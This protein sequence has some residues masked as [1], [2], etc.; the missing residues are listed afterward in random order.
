[1]QIPFFQFIVETEGKKEK[2]GKN[3]ETIWRSCFR[4]NLK[5]VFWGSLDAYTREVI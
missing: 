2:L 1:M 4:M 5:C 3:R